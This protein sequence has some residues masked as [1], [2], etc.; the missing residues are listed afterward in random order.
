MHH[1]KNWPVAFFSLLPLPFSPSTP[2]YAARA[3]TPRFVDTQPVSQALSTPPEIV[4]APLLGLEE[5]TLG[6]SMSFCSQEGGPG[7][8]ALH[9]LDRK[10]WS[11]GEPGNGLEVGDID[12]VQA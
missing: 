10:F 3:F 1:E 6:C 8:E 12:S 5:P 2:S 11:L 9:C 4:P 7:K